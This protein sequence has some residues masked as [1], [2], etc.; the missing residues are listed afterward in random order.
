MSLNVD[1]AYCVMD[2]SVDSVCPLT[3]FI[4]CQISHLAIIGYTVQYR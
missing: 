3:L 2:W 4:F 1:V